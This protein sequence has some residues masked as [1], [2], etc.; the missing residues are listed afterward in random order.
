M[1]RSIPRT[2]AA[3]LAISLHAEAQQSHAP[4]D[5]KGEAVALNSA[6]EACETAGQS[7]KALGLYRQAL[8]L[9]RAAGEKAAVATT[10]VNIHALRQKNI[11]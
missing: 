8:P 5:L 6:G 3:L 1:I 10:L 9:A 2:T 4:R 7:A 11:R